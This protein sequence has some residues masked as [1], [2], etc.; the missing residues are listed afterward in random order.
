M[1]RQEFFESKGAK[2]YGTL[3]LPEG[4]EKPS[5]CLF[6]GGSFPQ[7]R[8]GNIDNSKTDWFPKP[9]PERNLF[10]DEAIILEEIGIATFRYDKR[11]C[12]QSEGNFNTTRL[13][14]LVDDA[15]MALEW[16]RSIPEIDSSRIGVLGQSEGAVIALILAASDPDI[17][18][19]VWQGGI[20]NNLE[21]IIKWQAE[22]FEKLDSTTIKNFKK[23]MPLIYWT[24]KQFDEIIAS[25]KRGEEFFRIG[26]ED[27]SFNSYL[28]AAQEHFDN[29]P[30]LFVDK[31]KCPV[32][33][34][35]G[36]LDHNTPPEEAQ[37]MQQ[38]LID[39]GNRNVTTHIFPGLDHSFRR[40]GDPDED[41]VTA[42]KRPLDPEMP[43][44]L[45]N[46]LKVWQQK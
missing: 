25:A 3:T 14:D 22:A 9:L 41:F 6:I 23:N 36:A 37:E 28:P 11:G 30:Y 39:A 26:D 1:E 24:Y 33:I 20:Y 15:R 2:I 31:V 16:M 40:L 7:T 29:P 43:Q 17:N 21:G 18:F 35:H 42:M 12:G 10:R 32:L 4:V 44:A 13:F 5:A 46:W 38:A 27:W 19:F 34:L 45:T 8:E